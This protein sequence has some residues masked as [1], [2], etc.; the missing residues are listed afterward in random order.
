MIGC[1]RLKH[2]DGYLAAVDALPP[3]LV[4]AKVS[5]EDLKSFRSLLRQVHRLAVALE[6]NRC[7]AA[8]PSRYWS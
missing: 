5:L 8:A 4:S 1:A 7:A 3:A 6:F 2:I